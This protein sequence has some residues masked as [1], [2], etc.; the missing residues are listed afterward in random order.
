MTYAFIH[1]VTAQALRVV[2]RVHVA[3]HVGTG[4]QVFCCGKLFAFRRILHT[5]IIV[6]KG[7][8]PDILFNRLQHSKER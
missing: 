8:S 4:D 6:N 3:A 1:R 5:P 7:N 2:A